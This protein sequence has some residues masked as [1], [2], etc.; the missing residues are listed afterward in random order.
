MTDRIGDEVDGLDETIV[1]YDSGRR[2]HPNRDI[3]DDE[4]YDWLREL[5][6]KTDNVVCVFDCGHT[7][8]ITRDLFLGEPSIGMP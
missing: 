1:P 2:P 5:T 7:G 3:T 8:S 6:Q 4:L